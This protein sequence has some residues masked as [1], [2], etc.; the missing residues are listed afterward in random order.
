M[1]NITR[2][3][4]DKTRDISFRLGFQWP[5]LPTMMEIEIGQHLFFDYRWSQDLWRKTLYLEDNLK[6]NYVKRPTSKEEEE[7]T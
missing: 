2:N 7:E 4:P 3:Q 5:L 1:D 6:E